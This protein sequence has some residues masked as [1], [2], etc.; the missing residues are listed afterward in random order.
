MRLKSIFIFLVA[1]F[2]VALAANDDNYSNLRSKA[3]RFFENEEWASANA[4]YLLMLEQEPGCSQTYARA[5]VADIMAGDTVQALEMIT[6]SMSYEVPFDSLLSEVRATSFSIGHGDLYCN[7]LLKIKD[8]YPWL[9]R[10]ADNYLMQYYDFRQNGPELIKYARTMLAGLPDDLDFMRM[11]AH[12]LLLTGHTDEAVE[13]WH[14]IVSLYPENY[15]TVLD[16]ANFYDA[17]C[18]TSQALEWMR[19][20]NHLHPTPY[21]ASRI[22]ALSG[23]N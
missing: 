21:V 1:G 6:A 3:K 2:L 10:V 9:N 14:N 23:K 17:T 8:T 22:N 13:Q 5:I 15:D 20:A 19:R 7:F 4:M 12:G 16:L 18:D 11:L